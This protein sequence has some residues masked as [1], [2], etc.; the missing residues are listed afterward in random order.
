[1][2]LLLT[3]QDRLKARGI[4]D[5]LELI[6]GVVMD[7]IITSNSRKREV[8]MLRH[9]SIYLIHKNTHWSYQ[10]LAEYIGLT[11]H[12]SV[13]HALKK[14]NQWI[15]LPHYYKNEFNLLTQIETAY[16]EKCKDSI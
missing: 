10:T 9:L 4:L 6:T 3:K 15:E 5:S 1:M 2:K 16:G 13:M 12:T 7:D 8:V 14:I 11:N